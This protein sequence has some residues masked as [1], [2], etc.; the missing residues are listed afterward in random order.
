MRF[1]AVAISLLFSAS[2]T[3]IPVVNAQPS[4][5]AICYECPERDNAGVLLADTP[6]MGA[7]PFTC[8][9]GDAGSCNYTADGALVADNNTNGCPSDALDLCARRR[10]QARERAL[11]RSPRPPSPA[12][13]QPKPKVMQLRKNLSAEKAKLGRDA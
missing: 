8:D 9:Y 7:N 11:P 13:Y 6:N 3:L 1:S 5:R 12:A 4:L 2:T 10:R